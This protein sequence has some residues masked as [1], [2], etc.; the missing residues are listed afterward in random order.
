MTSFLLNKNTS[1]NLGPF[2]YDTA[3]ELA[4]QIICFLHISI[5]FD[6]GTTMKD[7]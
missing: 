4:V 7:I 5:S 3:T 1:L 6:D 2:V